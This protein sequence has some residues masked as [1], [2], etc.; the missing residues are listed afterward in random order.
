MP[1]RTPVAIEREWV[2]GRF[3]APMHVMEGGPYRPQVTLWIELPEPFIVGCLIEDPKAAAPF[4]ETLRKAMQQP[5][6]GSTRRPARV[7]V[8]DPLHAAELRA[9]IPDVEVAVAPTP[10][11]DVV[12][13]DLTDHL[14]ESA[15]Q[16][17]EASYLD[18]G[19][20]PAE[21]VDRLFG[22]AKLLYDIA[23]W[24]RA[25]DDQLLRVDVPAL[26]VEG[27]CLCVIGA[28]GEN[29]GFLLF[30]S[31]DGYEAFGNA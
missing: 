30:P 19:R 28:L 21:A 31:L 12:V 27:A 23:P 7:R 6:V 18:G 24:K 11:L 3:P 8:A 10:E 13:R 1:Q 22:A 15:P 17:Q 25:T 14:R 9:A 2:G 5:M 20:I 4:P 29:L 16:E 26:G